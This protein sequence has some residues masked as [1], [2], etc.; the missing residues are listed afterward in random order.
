MANCCRSHSKLLF[1]TINMI[2][3]PVL[4]SSLFVL[5]QSTKKVPCHKAC[6]RESIVTSPVQ[7]QASLLVLKYNIILL[8]KRGAVGGRGRKLEFII[9]KKAIPALEVTSF[10]YCKT[11]CIDPMA[12]AVFM[13]STYL[14]YPSLTQHAWKFLF[15][16][17]SSPRSSLLLLESIG[18]PC[19]AEGSSS[20]GTSR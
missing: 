10:Q 6:G 11:V 14:N 2:K 15:K 8:N 3:L 20:V 1:V 9:F 18:V 17:W 5:D 7:P 19:W 4:C 12:T 16:R 13:T